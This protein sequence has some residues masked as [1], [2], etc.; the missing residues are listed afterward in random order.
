MAAMNAPIPQQ[1]NR[2]DEKPKPAQKINPDA[3]AAHKWGIARTGRGF[4]VSADEL[5]VTADGTL[6]FRQTIGGKLT[7]VFVLPANQ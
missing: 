2:D 6:V 1:E 7:T 4:T 5:T 3:Q